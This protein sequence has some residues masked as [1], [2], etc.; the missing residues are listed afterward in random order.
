[1]EQSGELPKWAQA[2]WKLSGNHFSDDIS[3]LWL[4][5]GEHLVLDAEYGI[6]LGDAY[7]FIGLGKVRVIRVA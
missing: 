3:I 7:G 2:R 6:S 4:R 5:I 1:M